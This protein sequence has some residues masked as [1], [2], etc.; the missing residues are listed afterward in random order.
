MK[1]IT[2]RQLAPEK[3]IHYSRDHLRRKCKA[4]EFPKPIQ[5]S[6]SRI[7]WVDSEIDKFIASRLAERDAAEAAR[8]HRAHPRQPAAPR[9]NADALRRAAAGPALAAA[10]LEGDA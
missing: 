8:G 3:G 4:G 7:A 5:V 10:P 2:F 1:L 6:D 9:D